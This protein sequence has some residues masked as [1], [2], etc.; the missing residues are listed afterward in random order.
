MRK[1]I[2]IPAITLLIAASALAQTSAPLPPIRI[3]LVGDSTMAIEERVWA[4]VLRR[5]D[6]VPEVTCPQYGQGRAQFR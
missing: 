4:R 5:R 3:I 2:F 1:Q 6:L